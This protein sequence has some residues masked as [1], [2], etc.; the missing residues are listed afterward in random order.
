MFVVCMFI[1]TYVH[2]FLLCLL[3]LNIYICMF[4]CYEFRKLVDIKIL[5]LTSNYFSYLYKKKEVS[6]SCQV[7]STTTC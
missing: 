4:V 2:Q 5:N 3:F 6:T 7:D 1:T